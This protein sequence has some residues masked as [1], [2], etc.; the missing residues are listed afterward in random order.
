MGIEL[1]TA[2]VA[3]PGR[4]ADTA[5][6]AENAGWWGVTITDSQNLAG[7]VYVAM[8]VAAAATT[9]LRVSTGVTNPHTRHPAVAAAALW[10]VHMESGGRAALGLGRGDSSLAHLGLPPAPVEQ[11]T[12]YLNQLQ[13]Y[14]RGEALPL[15]WSE[16]SNLAVADRPTESRLRW[17][18]LGSGLDK[19]PVFVVGSGP[20]VLRAAA[21]G[22]DRVVLAVGADPDRIRWAV[23]T[24]K[25]V[26]AD[27]P[28]GAFVNAVVDDDIDRARMLAAGGVASFARFSA[29]H[30]H[31]S[32]RLAGEQRSVIES[33]PKVYDLNRHFQT[34]PHAQGLPAEFVDR[35]AIVG[36]PARVVDRIAE[37]SE[38]GIDQFQIVGPTGDVATD[39]AR[40]ARR[41]F[42]DDVLPALVT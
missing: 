18:G 12:D 23:E 35:F 2:M 22:A 39:A 24:V 36:A 7:D 29:M 20:R 17:L 11:L 3:I 34:A 10:H 28:V 42:A 13:T 1:W 19:P 40:A 31:A 6:R 41:R 25:S 21:A 38:L 37:L 16:V 15:D 32:G 33:I 5:A 8:S 30:G 26:R 4:I 9:T 27:A 14:L